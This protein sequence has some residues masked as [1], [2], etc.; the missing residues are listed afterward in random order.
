MFI[1]SLCLFSLSIFSLSL[2]SH[3]SFC[4]TIQQQQLSTNQVREPRESMTFISVSCVLRSGGNDLEALCSVCCGFYSRHIGTSSCARL[5]LGLGL[6]FP[7]AQPM[8]RLMVGVGLGWGPFL[9]LVAGKSLSQPS[10]SI[11]QTADCQQRVQG[12]TSRRQFVSSQSSPEKS[13]S[14]LK[15]SSF[16]RFLLL[17]GPYFRFQTTGGSIGADVCANFAESTSFIH[18]HRMSCVAN[19]SACSFSRN[20]LISR[21]LRLFWNSVSTDASGGFSANGAKARNCF[22]DAIVVFFVF[23][24]GNWSSSLIFGEYFVNIQDTIIQ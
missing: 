7:Q 18:S 10:N 3:R 5:S 19:Q 2:F 13:P 22:N 1:S 20:M 15:N 8:L 6:G 21:S 17:F 14:L 11:F 24:V 4:D 16:S 23:V 9:I 12:G